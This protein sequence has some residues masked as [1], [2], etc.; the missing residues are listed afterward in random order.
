M[1]GDYRR[2][3]SAVLAIS[4]AFSPCLMAWNS[5]GHMMVAALAWKQLS[6]DTL[7]ARA[8]ALLKLN[9][10]YSKWQS[11]IPAGTAAEDVPQMI[12][13]IAATWP[14]QI[15]SESG[16]TNDKTPSATNTGYSDKKQHRYWHFVDTPFT[17]DGS[18][19]PVVPSPNAATQIAAFRTV[20]K[21]AK[22]DALK[23]YDLVWLLHLV[24]DVHQP[25]HATTRVSTADPKGDSGGNNVKCGSPCPSE[26]HGYWDD[27]L[28][29][30]ENP[31]PVLAA[32]LALPAADPEAVKIA[33]ESTWIVESFQLAED[34]VYVLPIGPGDG[35]FTLT[36][37]YETKAKAVAQVRVAL[38]GAR[39]AE[40]IDANLK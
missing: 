21:S 12:F 27:L 18:T 19:L 2:R 22:P 10:D 39:L 29:T 31:V 23:S 14:D 17:Q 16:Y 8:T 36:V 9:P 11:M 6:S 38:A 28:G 4:L 20:L 33:D 5:Q 1:K 30:S 7:R 35:P 40:L 15:K 24:G 32:A 25:L 37:A 3:S 13:M 26:L 34:D